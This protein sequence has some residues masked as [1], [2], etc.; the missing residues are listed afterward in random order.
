[1]RVP[2]NRIL[3]GWNDFWFRPRSASTLAL[4]RIATGAMLAYVHA[5]W[6]LRLS[7]FMGHH[8]LI[9]NEH[10]RRLHQNDFAWSYLWDVRDMPTLWLH[11]GIAILLAICLC[12]GFLTRFASP[13]IWFMTLMVCH[14]MTGFLF[15]LDQVVMMLAMYLILAPTGSRWSVD[16]W[17]SRRLA[18]GENSM[19]LLRWLFPSTEPSSMTTIASRLI[20][21][22]LCIVYLFGGIAKLRGEMWWDGTAMWFSAVAYEYQSLDLTWLG[23]YSLMGAILSHVTVF[24]ETFYC[25]LIWQRWSRPYFLAIAVAVHG[26][27]ALFLGMITFGMMMIVANLVFIE[28]EW[29]DRMIARRRLQSH[30]T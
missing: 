24:W 25:V 17:L 11:Q 1:M 5:V 14:R 22:H 8:A 7:D 13:M 4:I 9:D 23:R 21:I 26:G 6:C 16:A 3:D 29:I 12:I 15:G 28:P 20:Q 2:V 27:I 10:I 19:K 18:R 30:K